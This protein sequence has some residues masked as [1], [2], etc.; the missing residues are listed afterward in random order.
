MSEMKLI[1]M[2]DFR[3]AH[4]GK[5]RK[6]LAVTLGP[7]A[8]VCFLMV[9]GNWSAAASIA[10]N[11]VAGK[12]AA[13]DMGGVGL[14]AWPR[15]RGPNGK[16]EVDGVEF[17][18]RWKAEDYR[19]QVKLPG[20]GHSSPVV[21]GDKI[22]VTTGLSDDG[23]QILLAFQAQDGKLLWEKHYPGRLHRL[24]QFNSYASSTPALDNRRIFWAWAIP[25][26]L[27]VVALDQTTGEEL[28]R[29]E[30]GPFVSE[31]GFGASPVVIGDIVVLA[32]E[33][34]GESFVIALSAETGEIRWKT[35]RRT[36]K[37][38]YSTPCL[39][40]PPEGPPQLILASWAHGVSSL[41]LQTG[42]VLWEVPVF[43]YR[44]VGS[45]Y[46][47][48]GS[49]I[50]SCGEGGVGRQLA[51][52]RPPEKPGAQPK[53][54]LELKQDI[55]YVPT[56]VG[57]GSLAF[58]WSD[59]GVI[60][61]V[62]VTNSQVLW[63]ERVGGQYFASPIRIGEQLLNISR[64]GEVVIV[65]ASERFELLARFT[66]E[67]GTHATPAVAGDTLYI[68]TYSRLAALP[69]RPSRSH[70]PIPPAQK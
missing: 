37:T 41:D 19:W 58:L 60:T 44:V 62:D 65:R 61:C 56:A 55:P 15:F 34:D 3:Q 24:H 18:L 67:E 21:M 51:I 42:S 52:L 28:W 59:R 14:G 32:N 33:Q 66:I 25:E 39:F 12:E 70:P 35:P 46:V 23:T 63:K 17:P 40:Q 64:Q 8:C 2:T 38:A 11:I 7:L 45:P 57:Y 20:M 1:A 4:D 27:I 54:M 9:V 68:R 13:G 29:R 49:V 50:A 10:D 53:I 16:G 47:V 31:H 36:E 30:L 26:A 43:R 22:F 48:G 6:S 69:G 5:S